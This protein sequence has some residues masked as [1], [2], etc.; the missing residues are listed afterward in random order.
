MDF[1]VIYLEMKNAPTIP[2]LPKNLMNTFFQKA[3]EF[4]EMAPWDQFGDSEYFGVLIPE[5]NE[6]QFVSIM[7]GGG[8]CFG[9][10]T[11]RGIIG[12][13]FLQELLTGE[14]VEDPFFMR[15]NQDGLLLEFTTKKYLDEA[16]LELAKEANF[17]PPT[18]KAWP[19]IR[20]LKPGYV[21][22]FPET[23]DINALLRVM[24]ATLTLLDLVDENPDCLFQDSGKKFP[25]FV[26]NKRS[27][28]W[29]LDRWSQKKIES[30]SIEN[31]EKFHIPPV[32]ELLLQK[33]KS[34]PK[35]LKFNIELHDFFAREPILE[36]DRPFYPRI[37]AALEK[38]SGACL[39]MDLI[40]PEKDVSVTCRDLV[41]NKIVEFGKIPKSIT[42]TKPEHFIGAATLKKALNI[43]IKFED[44]ECGVEF[45]AS[46]R[47]KMEGQSF[48]P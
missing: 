24:S 31:E 26:W 23:E 35:D 11:Y 41:L 1:F 47:E 8:Q 27:S 36:K 40:S 33:S 6:I 21:P 17:K 9:L 48:N 2:T 39:G 44:P 7:G 45:E 46:F 30:T 14:E 42:V 15:L 12:L 43:D 16:D 20:N 10:A 28:G 13:A 3:A 22:W 34:L 25:M 29:K 5:T 19:L 4:Y 18:A 38:G 37:C 32:D